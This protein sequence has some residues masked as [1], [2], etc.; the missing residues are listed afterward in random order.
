MDGLNCHLVLESGKVFSGK[1]FG[2]KKQ[3]D[4][5]IGMCYILLLFFQILLGNTWLDSIFPTG[6]TGLKFYPTAPYS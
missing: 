3:V 5:E 6:V 1:S 4:G 2:A